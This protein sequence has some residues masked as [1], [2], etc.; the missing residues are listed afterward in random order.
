MRMRSTLEPANGIT[1]PS[2]LYFELVENAPEAIIVVSN[3]K[4]MFTNPAAKTLIGL[5]ES[6]VVTDGN[7]LEF[8]DPD[9]REGAAE[10]I[11]ALHDRRTPASLVMVTL[12]SVDGIQRDVELMTR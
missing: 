2:H 6:T 10:L 9:S 5:T 7:V 8:A 4:L 3:G 11:R 12:A 1:T